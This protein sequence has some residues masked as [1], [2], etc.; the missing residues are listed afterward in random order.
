MNLKGTM[1]QKT[2]QRCKHSSYSMININLKFSEVAFFKSTQQCI[3][4]PTNNFI[5]KYLHIYLGKNLNCPSV[6]LVGPGEVFDEKNQ[7]SKI[8]LDCP[9][10]RY[11]LKT[12]TI[13][14]TLSFTFEN[15]NISSRG[16][17]LH[18]GLT[19]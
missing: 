10:K 2:D 8:L 11:L 13:S 12:F 5:F 1:L 6:S 19:D 16:K 14:K 4:H 18:N 17:M 3:L 15:V 7:H 9:F